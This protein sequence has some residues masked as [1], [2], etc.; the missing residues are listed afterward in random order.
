VSEALPSTNQ[1]HE[2]ERAIDVK[3][4]ADLVRP[5][6]RRTVNKLPEKL[7]RAVVS[8]WSEHLKYGARHKKAI[9]H[10]EIVE[11]AQAI[12]PKYSIAQII[13]FERE[14]GALL[15][16]GPSSTYIKRAGLENYPTSFYLLTTKYPRGLL[17]L[18]LAGAGIRTDSTCGLPWDTRML[19]E[20]NVVTIER[21]DDEGQR[22]W[23][24]EDKMNDIKCGDFVYRKG[25][26][27]SI[28]QV[29]DT[30]PGVLAVKLSDGSFANL[31]DLVPT[32]LETKGEGIEISS[33]T[34]QGK[35]LVITTTDNRIFCFDNAVCIGFNIEPADA[36]DVD[37]ADVR[38]HID[39]RA[40]RNRG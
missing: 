11:L 29:V 15:R 9:A 7:I 25:S 2:Q 17:H 20:N 8:W 37:S 34:Q 27:R 24:V 5:W 4:L 23:P 38:F 32:Q 1:D 16:D 21:G 39:L 3:E 22:I 33:F 10:H 31:C 18:A 12:I 13:T 40:R 28:Y 14:L 35:T 26:E 30:L 6:R 36:L 19:I